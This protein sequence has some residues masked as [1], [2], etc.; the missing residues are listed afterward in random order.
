MPSCDV[1]RNLIIR[2][3]TPASTERSLVFHLILV[4]LAGDE[5]QLAIELQE[6]D[7]FNEFEN[8]VLENLPLIGMHS[9]FGCELEFI[10][11][12]TQKIL[13]DPIWNTL[14]D[15]NCFNLILRKCFTQAQRKGQLR[16]RVKAVSV[17]LD[18]ADRVLPHASSHVADIKHVR[19]EV[20]IH[21]IGEA[22]WQ[23]CLRLQIVK[24]PSTIICLQDGVF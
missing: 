8:A 19:V 22:A 24:L 11:M 3:Y 12:D 21:T 17:P 16:R 7:R 15:C 1:R 2:Q 10:S 14:Q 13:V 20:G 23:S 18:D 4:T 5:I 9:T 6:F